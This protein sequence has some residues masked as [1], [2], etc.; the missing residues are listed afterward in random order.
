MNDEDSAL[1]FPC[2]FPIKAMGRS[3]TDLD[4]VVVEIVRRH[5]PDLAEG[6]VRSR[7]STHGKYISVT[8]TV[9]ATSRAQLDAIYQDLVDCD[10]VIM[11]L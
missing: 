1:Q 5:V 7:A 6:A 3:G 10:T 4:L 8:V 2:L 11:A 9:T